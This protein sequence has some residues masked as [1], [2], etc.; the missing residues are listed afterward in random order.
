MR[1]AKAIEWFAEELAWIEAR[2]DWPRVDLHRAFVNFWRRDDVSLGAFKSLCKRKG[3]MTGRTGGFPPGHVPANKGKKQAYNPNT[4]RTQFQKGQK[5]FNAREPGYEYTDR[6]G[7]VMICVDEPNPWTGSRT[8]MV[9]KQRRLW[10]QAN[11]PVPAGMRL[12]SLDGDK[13][14][15]DPA[16]W[17]ALPIGMA[18]RL[19]G[20]FGRGYDAAPAEVKPTIMAAAKLEHELR[21]LKPWKPKRTA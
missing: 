6:D 11:G 19:N 9:H 16:N 1:N 18:V 4:A 3:F 14:N 10:E 8:R 17:E 12:K 21:K 7:Y 2:K 5:P 15:C 13:T 20:R